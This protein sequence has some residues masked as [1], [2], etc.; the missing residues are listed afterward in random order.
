M[1]TCPMI[2]SLSFLWLFHHTLPPHSTVLHRLRCSSMIWLLGRWRRFRFSGLS[3]LLRLL[4]L[5]LIAP[6]RPRTRFLLV[7]LPRRRGRLLPP[8]LP[9]GEYPRFHRSVGRP[10]RFP[11]LRGDPSLPLLLRFRLL[12]LPWS[13]FGD[14]VANGVIGISIAPLLPRFPRLL[15]PSGL[16][17]G[18]TLLRR[19]GRLP[20]PLAALPAPQALGMPL[21]FLR[22]PACPHLL[23]NPLARLLP[24][25]LGPLSRRTAPSAN[26]H[27]PLPVGSR[28]PVFI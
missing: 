18:V 23:P 22:S 21:G 24:S 20:R 8:P 25:L 13:R 10:S 5:L 4:L 11:P 16:L 19:V 7:L 28:F 3:L 17:S 1:S 6:H 14:L 12:P 2:L 15:L 27:S 9:V 26:F